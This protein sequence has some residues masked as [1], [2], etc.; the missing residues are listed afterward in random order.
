MFYVYVL[1]S[2]KT[3]R[4]YVGQTNDLWRRFQEHES[5]MTESI[6]HQTPFAIERVELHA[7]RIGAIKRER[8]LKSGVGREWLDDTNG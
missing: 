6:K 4:R 1:R 3:G 2:L 8:W 5:G 7:D